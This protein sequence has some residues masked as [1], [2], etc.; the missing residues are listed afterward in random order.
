[1]I[2]VPVRP[3]SPAGEVKPEGAQAEF[4]R[5]VGLYGGIVVKNLAGKSTHLFVAAIVIAAFL[6]SAVNMPTVTLAASSTSDSVSVAPQKPVIT[7][8]SLRSKVYIKWKSCG[9]GATYEIWRKKASGGK[10]KCVGE[11][12]KNKYTDSKIE[13]GSE[14]SYRVRAVSGSGSDASYSEYSKKKTILPC[15]ID[16]KKKMVALTFDDGPGTNTMDIVNCL[17]KYGMHATFFV[18]GSNAS[19]YKDTIKAEYAAGCEIGNHTWIHSNL[20]KLSTAAAKSTVNKTNK[21]I[22][23]ITGEAP[24]LLRP[25]YGSTSVAVKSAIK[26]P[27]IMWSIDTLDWKTRNTA[28]T[29]T[30]VMNNVKDGSIVLMHDIHLPTVKAAQ[31]IIPKLVDKGYQ[32][33]TV[34]ELAKYKGVTLKNGTTYGS[35]R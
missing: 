31:N 24:V 12:S 11:T 2:P 35:I 19:R 30:S 4:S 17:R 1:M 32:L 9:E 29:I 8:S 23:S 21:L 27:Q 7:L 26:M 14:Y 3:R 34:S 16:P 13:L 25:P 5:V 10:W 28:K 20:V 33:V 18:V 22:K 6:L 15:A